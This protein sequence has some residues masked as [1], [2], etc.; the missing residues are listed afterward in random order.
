V[1]LFLDAELGSLIT[2]AIRSRQQQQVRE[3]CF[4]EPAAPVVAEYCKGF[5]QLF[6]QLLVVKCYGLCCQ[7]FCSLVG[8]ICSFALQEGQQQ[9][10]VSLG[11]DWVC[12][13]VGL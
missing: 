7:G 3:G 2:I 1:V 13:G 6:L 8:V 11:F 5:S 9:L 4:A 12:W 10:V